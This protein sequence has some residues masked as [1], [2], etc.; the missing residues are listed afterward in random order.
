MKL[1][2][3]FVAASI[4]AM[5]AAAHAQGQPDRSTLRQIY[6]HADGIYSYAPSIID[7]GNLRYAWSCHNH[8]PFVVRDDIV[9]AKWENGRLVEDRSVLTHSFFGWDSF[10]ICDPSVMRSEIVFNNAVYHWVMFF[11]GNNVDRSAQNQIGVAMA[12]TIE[13]PWEKLPQ[14]VL[15]QVEGGGWG[16]GQPSA[17]PVDGKGKFL[18]VYSGEGLHTATVDLSDLNHIIVSTP[19]EVSTKGLENL[20][21]LGSAVGNLDIAYGPGH[22]RIYAV[23]DIRTREKQYPGFITSRLAVLSIGA[24]DVAR[25]TGVWRVEATIGP[26]QTGF[27]RNHNAGLVRDADGN[28]AGGDWL[29]VVFARSCAAGSN[30]PCKANT[31]A[32]WT[33]DLWEI[34]A[35]L[36]VLGEPQPTHSR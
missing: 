1:R 22:R 11:L 28:L 23:G 20:A 2:K 25:G 32:E 21:K 19:V 12:Q 27:P 16:I 17:L 5:A 31:R 33:Y 36:H 8:D 7:L 9:M 24:E 26:E 29:T 3:F 18:I 6:T 10:H 13:G 35:P 34:S 30:M 14:P 15:T 4:F